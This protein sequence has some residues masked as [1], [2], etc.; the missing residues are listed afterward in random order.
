MRGKRGHL[1]RRLRRAFALFVRTLA[2]ILALQLSGAPHVIEDLADTFLASESG[3]EHH[4]CDD[5]SDQDCPPGCPSCHC[6]HPNVLPSAQT[7]DLFAW[8]GCLPG[9]E[10]A[11]LPYESTAPPQPQLPSVFRPPRALHV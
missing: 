4:D 6:T 5:E 10:L 7:D 3:I 9:S 2:A 1:T 8:L 11:D